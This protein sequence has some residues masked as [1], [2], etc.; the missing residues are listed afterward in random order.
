MIQL[1][2]PDQAFLLLLLIF[3]LGS[4]FV[5]AF[6]ELE[7]ARSRWVSEQPRRRQRPRE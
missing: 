5:R 1:A 6:W 4:C 3:C 7:Q 2:A